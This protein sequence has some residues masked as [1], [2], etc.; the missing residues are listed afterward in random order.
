MLLVLLLC[1]FLT[2]LG[3]SLFLEDKIKGRG[4]AG[5]A[6]IVF[7]LFTTSWTWSAFVGF[8]IS[9]AEGSRVGYVTKA[10]VKGIIFKTNEFEVQVGQGQM[11]ALQ[12]P[13]PMSCPDDELWGKI[14]TVQ[15]SGDKVQIFYTQVWSNPWCMGSTSYRIQRVEKSE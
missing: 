13:Y 5:F 3:G 14:L 9:Y 1:L 12:K 11:A 6:A 8:P 4:C 7:F 15:S 2:L 10:S